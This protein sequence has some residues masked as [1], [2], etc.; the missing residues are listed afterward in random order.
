MTESVRTEYLD[1]IIAAAGDFYRFGWL[2]AASGNMSARIDDETL[3]ITA[4]G[5]HL[6][7]LDAEDF[8]DI[9]FDGQATDGGDPSGDTAIHLAIYRS[10]DEVGAVYHI[11]HLEAALCSDRDRKRGFTHFQEIQMLAALGD[12]STANVPI[13][14]AA[15][16]ELS[17]AIAEKL[18]AD[19]ELEVPCINVKNHGIYVWGADPSQARRHVE[20]L[21]YLFE[22]SWQRPMNP[23]TSSSITG[24]GKK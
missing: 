5:T 19:D 14:D 10:L 18:S 3:S 6:R 11:H 17:D 24:F 9:D 7:Q 23:K 15:Y 12:A 21:A 4:T 16:D 1:E 8:V 13:V 20:A 2:G 22:Y